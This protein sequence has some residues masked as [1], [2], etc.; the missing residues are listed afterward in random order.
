PSAR[1]LTERQ[2]SAC[3]SVSVNEYYTCSYMVA[4]SGVATASAWLPD[5]TTS[6]L[7]SRHRGANSSRLTVC[8]YRRTRQPHVGCRLGFV[9]TRCKVVVR[10]RGCL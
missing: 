2:V 9:E 6:S 4:Q 8:V 7:V 10:S 3:V 1:R 5:N